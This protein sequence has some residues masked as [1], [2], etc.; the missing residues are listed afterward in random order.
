M[1]LSYPAYS[2]TAQNVDYI[3]ANTGASGTSYATNIGV[4]DHIKFTTIESGNITLDVATPYVNTNNTASLGR[5]LLLA[6][7]TYSLSALIAIQ[8][9]AG[10][11][12]GYA[13]FNSDT[14][15]QLG[16]EGAAWEVQSADINSAAS[17]EA[18]AIFTPTVNTRV[19]VRITGVSLLTSIY[20]GNPN[21][22]GTRATIIQLGSSAATLST[23]PS[24]LQ[25]DNTGSTAQIGSAGA[26]GILFNT[27][28]F[29]QGT[30][31]TNA[32]NTANILLAGGVSGTTYR[33][34]GKVSVTG[35]TG[36]SYIFYSFFNATTAT[37]FGADGYNVDPDNGASGAGWDE[38]PSPT[39]TGYIRVPAGTTTTIQLRITATGG[40]GAT[41]TIRQSSGQ[42]SVTIEEIKD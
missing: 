3:A 40:G 9:S 22:A 27:Q 10:G 35:S 19:E 37:R 28:L 13:W 26:S 12:M 14:G 4:G 39:A 30:K 36:A 29:T 20:A 21:L 31:I 16:K 42:T 7:R 5:F 8:A 11:R 25:L 23:I 17:G 1:P 34:D 6:N 18:E 32:G 41:G 2:N 15:I 24:I 33:C 38:I